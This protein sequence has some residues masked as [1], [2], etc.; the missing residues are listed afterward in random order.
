MTDRLVCPFVLNRT[1]L[2]IQ[3]RHLTVSSSNLTNEF[4]SL[5]L[6]EWLCLN[7]TKPDFFAKDSRD[8]IC[9]SELFVGNYG[10]EETSEDH[11][12]YWNK[13]L[14]FDSLEPSSHGMVKGELYGALKAGQ[15]IEFSGGV[16]RWIIR[17]ARNIDYGTVESI[18]WS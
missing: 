10:R 15:G 2:I 11:C 16:G 1:L 6:K 8:W 7:F 3:C 9:Y 18:R 5:E 14:A 12:W 17:F 13:G 4:R